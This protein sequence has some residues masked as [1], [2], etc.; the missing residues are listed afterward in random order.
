MCVLEALSQQ[1]KRAERS[2]MAVGVAAASLAFEGTPED[3]RMA[4]DISALRESLNEVSGS[5][6]RWASGPPQAA[7][8]LT[9][10]LGDEGLRVALKLFR[11]SL[12]ESPE[13]RAERERKRK[14]L[15]L[16]EASEKA[17]I[18]LLCVQPVPGFI[19]VYIPMFAYGH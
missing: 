4:I 19:S 16:P 5:L 11:W 14:E 13:V 6:A 2:S 9:K 18:C 15:K 7:G 3:R 12:K 17:W 10:G 1:M 8:C